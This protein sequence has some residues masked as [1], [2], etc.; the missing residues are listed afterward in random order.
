MSMSNHMVQMP[1]SCS[2]FAQGFFKSEFFILG[3]P[4]K[5]GQGL[6]G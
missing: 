5:K 2:V 1:L 4:T 3:L 6:P